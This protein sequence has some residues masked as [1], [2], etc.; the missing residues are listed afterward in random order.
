MQDTVTDEYYSV[1]P[2]GSYWLEA[3]GRRVLIQSV[4]DYMDEVVEMGGQK[5][6]RQHQIF[7]YAQKLA[8]QF[9][10]MDV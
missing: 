3:L 2:D 10:S 7:L 4:N 8:Q 6:S 9:K 5:R 1:R